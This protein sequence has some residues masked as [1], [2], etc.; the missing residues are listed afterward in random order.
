ML[1]HLDLF[2]G[3]GGFALAC[4]WAGIETIGFVEI[5][6]YCQKVLKKHWPDVPIVEDIRDVEKIKEIVANAKVIGCRGEL[7]DNK[8]QGGKIQEGGQ[9]GNAWNQPFGRGDIQ[10]TESPRETVSKPSIILI[11]AGFPCQP[12]S[13]AGKRE[14]ERDDRYLWPETLAV[15]KAIKPQWVLLENV[16]GIINL[17]LDTVLSDLEGAGY[18]YETLVIPACAVNAWHRRDRIWIVANRRFNQ[19]RGRDSIRYSIRKD[20][21]PK[22]E[23]KGS[24]QGGQ[25]K[26]REW[27]EHDTSDGSTRPEKNVAD[28]QRKG[29]EGADAEGSLCRAGQPSEHGQRGWQTDW[30]AVESELGRMADGLS[31]GLDGYFDTEPNIPRV[32]TGIKNRKE[33]LQCLGNAI[34]PQVA[35]EIIKVIA[36]MAKV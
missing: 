1:A 35:Y 10:L 9:K 5:D 23:D 3:I 12:F 29:L 13:N 34:V 26:S 8:N 28:T 14:G 7:G 11:T 33:R 24:S 27:A 22:E 36:E 20:D 21:R 31:C 6:K 30:W 25:G 4:E 32:A 15:I 2:S 18:S 19:H 17:A 16:T